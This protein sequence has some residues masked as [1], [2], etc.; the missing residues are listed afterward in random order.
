MNKIALEKQKVRKK[1][2]FRLAVFTIA[3]T[4]VLA[5]LQLFLANRLAGFSGELAN[6]EKSE[7]ELVYA[8]ELLK[9]EVAHESSIAG[10]AIKATESS[11]ETSRNFL[12]VS[13][14][15]TFALLR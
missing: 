8:N 4:I 13:E 6:L 14:S 12:I 10:I 9:K 5:L 15:E 7:K 1:R 3:V 11:F 2:Y